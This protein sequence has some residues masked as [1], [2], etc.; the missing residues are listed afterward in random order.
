VTNKSNDPPRF[1]DMVEGVK[2]IENDRVN[3]YR[4]RTKPVALSKNR[5]RVADST[6]DFASIDYQQRSGIRETRFNPGIQKKLQRKIRQGQLV[7]E[8]RL[9]LHGYT[10]NQAMTALAEFLDHAVTSEFKMLIIIHGRGSRSD[11]EAVLKPM[12]RHWLATQSSVLAWC[13]AQPKHGGDGACYVYLGSR[14]SR[15]T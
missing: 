1:A 12:V 2:K 11:S 10:Q 4:D 5:S 9:D 14:Q 6:P 8:D 13:P 7:I 15:S 3:V